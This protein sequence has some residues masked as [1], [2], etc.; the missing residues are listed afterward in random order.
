[1][2][3][4]QA[5]SVYRRETPGTLTIKGVGHVVPATMTLDEF[6]SF[7]WP[8]GRHW[9]LIWGTTVM[10]PSPQPMHQGLVADIIDL[11]KLRP[12]FL[13]LPG[14]DL[15][16]AGQNSYLCP[17]IQVQK[18]EGSIRDLRVPLETLPLLVVEA[19]SPGTSANDLGAKRDAYATAGV[20]EYWVAD[21][22]TGALSVHVEPKTGSYEQLAADVEGFVA[23]PFLAARV[24]IRLTDRGYALETRPAR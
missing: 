22:S 23:S 13:V 3:P 8:Q 2:A 18:H 14:T 11:L 16:L 17:D 24:K 5:Y 9:E 15:R 6:E 7:P 1:M 20:P 12:G 19:L 21:P 10:T 4:V